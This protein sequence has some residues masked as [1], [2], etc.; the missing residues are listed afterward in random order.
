M[1]RLYLRLKIIDT[2]LFSHATLIFSINS[3][4]VYY[5]FTILNRTKF[6]LV[7]FTFD[8][9]EMAAFKLLIANADIVVK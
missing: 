9:L 5:T 8:I 1:L 7:D 6:L 4:L 3:F 2:N